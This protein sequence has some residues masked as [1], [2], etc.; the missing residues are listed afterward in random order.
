MKFIHYFTLFLLAGLLLS[1]CSGNSSNSTS[2]NSSGAN[3]PVG[4]PIATSNPGNSK[5]DQPYPLTTPQGSPTAQTSATE[6]LAVEAASALAAAKEALV[7][8]VGMDLTQ[9]EVVSIEKVEW[10][11][12]CLG[13]AGSNEM[14]LE[15]ITPGYRILLSANDQVYE[16]HTD[17]NGSLVRYVS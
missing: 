9:I 1:A 16:Y 13:A 5:T 12:S 14:C 17:L 4:Y 11:D 10:S 15:V 8:F 2:T 3:P 7:V 6:D